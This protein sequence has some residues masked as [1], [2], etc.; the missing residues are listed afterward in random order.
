LPPSARRAAVFQERRSRRDEP[1]RSGRGQAQEVRDSQPDRLRPAGHGR[2]ARRWRREG[3]GGAEMSMLSDILERPGH[4]KA[5]LLGAAV[6]AVVIVDW[7]YVYGPRQQAL[8]DLRAEVAQKRSEYEGKRSKADAR[9]AA[10]KELRDL[11]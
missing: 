4:Q 10:E 6:V 3:L 1:G 11:D 8:T 5:I 7:S 2:R 9:G